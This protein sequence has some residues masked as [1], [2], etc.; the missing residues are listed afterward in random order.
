MARGYKTGGRKRGTPNK[1]TQQIRDEI[2]GSGE[3][4]LEYMIRV[5]RDPSAPT[6]RRDDMAKAAAPYIHARLAAIEHQ[7]DI[8]QSYVMR[9]PEPA[10][11]TEEWEA[12]VAK[13]RD[14]IKH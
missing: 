4:P 10:A 7:G 5:M 11:T 14:E 2:V 6:E 9:I 13:R 3:R 12:Q 1:V 8:V